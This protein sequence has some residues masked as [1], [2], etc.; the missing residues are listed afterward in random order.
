VEWH[1][2]SSPR[3]QKLKVQT[4][5]GED[6]ASVFWDSE[7]LLLVEFLERGA[8]IN[9]ERHATRIISTCRFYVIVM[10]WSYNNSATFPCAD[11]I[12]MTF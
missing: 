1:H 12:Y 2:Q 11:L 10:N 4:S 9:S 3:K 6:T 8:T 5:V 7:G